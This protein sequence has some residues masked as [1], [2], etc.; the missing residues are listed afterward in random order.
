MLASGGCVIEKIDAIIEEH[1]VTYMCC[2]PAHIVSL[3]GSPDIATRNL[4]SLRVVVTGGAS[5]PL[6][7]IKDFGTKMPARLVELYG[8]LE[9]GMQACTLI[10][11]DPETVAGT[12]GRPIAEVLSKIVD[13]KGAVV[14]EGKGT[15]LLGDPLAVVLWIRD[16]VAAEGKKL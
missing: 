4:S 6:E 9:C 5:C 13:E 16:S 12:V 2:A 11:E 7:V 1:G 14:S 3:L 8:M 10:N 15:A